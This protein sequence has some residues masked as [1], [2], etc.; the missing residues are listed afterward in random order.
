MQ[1]ILSEKISQYG[2]SSELLERVQEWRPTT[3]RNTIWLAL[4]EETPSTPIRKRIKDNA[5]ELVKEY[6]EGLVKLQE[7]QEPQ[8]A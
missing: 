3:S 6:E 2:L 8:A 5:E 4:R 7:L 1:Y